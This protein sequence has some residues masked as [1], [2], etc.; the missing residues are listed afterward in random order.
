MDLSQDRLILELDLKEMFYG[1]VNLTEL[2]QDGIKWGKFRKHGNETSRT[3]EWRRFSLYSLDSSLGLIGSLWFV[4]LFVG[5][6]VSQLTKCMQI[7]EIVF[8]INLR[9]VP[10]GMKER[11]KAKQKGR[12]GRRNRETK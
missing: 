4:C 12:K 5:K 3:A 1:G 10:E 9:Y 8:Y 6:L 11:D 7:S 2:A